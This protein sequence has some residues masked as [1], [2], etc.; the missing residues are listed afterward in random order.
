M[1]RDKY[2]IIVQTAVEDP[3]YEDG[4]DSAFSTGLMAFCGSELDDHLM[5]YFITNGQLVRHPYQPVYND[6]KETSRDQVLAFFSGLMPD[7]AFNSVRNACLNYAKGFR[8]NK[9]IL[10]PAHKYYLYKRAGV[11]PSKLLT[12]LVYINQALNLVWDCYIKPDD[13]KNQAIVMNI[14]F[15]KKWIQFL[16]K[17]HPDLYGNIDNYFNGWRDRGLIG[18]KLK[19]KIFY[20][21]KE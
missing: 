3:S 2:Q 10:T 21:I 6:P 4:G 20:S 8:V 17:H 15:G 14:T 9:D 19:N 5:L 7:N 13:E 18:L 1:R 11:E 16:Y 12:V